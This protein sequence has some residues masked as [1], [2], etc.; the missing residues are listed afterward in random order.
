MLHVLAGPRD[1]L[2]LACP[3]FCTA[4]QLS[5]YHR[6]FDTASL[7][8]TLSREALQ[9]AEDKLAP[10]APVLRRAAAAAAK[11]RDRSGYKW[12]DL[13]SLYGRLA[14]APQQVAQ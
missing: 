1:K 11:L 4:S 13:G 10:I 14:L 5:Y 7:A 6:L 9:A 3:A 2:P 8:H 12:V